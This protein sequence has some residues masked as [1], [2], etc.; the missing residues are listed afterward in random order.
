MN[1]C[2]TI[3]FQRHRINSCQFNGAAVSSV[4]NLQPGENPVRRRRVRSTAFVILRGE[5]EV[6][7]NR[8]RGAV[9]ITR[10][11]N[12]W[13]VFGGI[14]TVVEAVA[15]RQVIAIWSGVSIDEDE[16]IVMKRKPT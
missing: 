9:R 1:W 13:L 10:P 11:G 5:F 6:F 16:K 3:S 14:K 12:S 7:L 15:A 8:P 4:A 2:G